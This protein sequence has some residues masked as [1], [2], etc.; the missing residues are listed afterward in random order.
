MNQL[1]RHGL[2]VLVRKV[3]GPYARVWRRTPGYRIGVEK[4]DRQAVVAEGMTPYHALEALAAF[5]ATNG[6]EGQPTST[7]EANVAPEPDQGPSR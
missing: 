2:E 7:P 3:L 5:L 4:G 6:G 1:S